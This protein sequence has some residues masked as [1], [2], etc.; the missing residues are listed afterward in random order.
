MNRITF[1][2]EDGMLGP[3]VADLQDALQQCFAQSAIPIPDP[4]TFT[5]LET[6]LQSE[7]TAQTYGPGTHNVVVAFQQGHKLLD[8][9]G[10]ASGAVDEPTASALNALLTQWGLLPPPSPDTQGTV[11]GQLVDGDGAPI[12]GMPVSLF[13]TYI[14]SETRLGDATTGKD[15]RYSIA[16][17]RPSPLNLVTRAYDAS[18]KVIAESTTVFAAAAQVEIN[19]TTA[20]NKVVGSPSIFTTLNSA[21]AGQLR[22]IP[23]S[24]LKE[25]KDTHE[26]HFLAS[27]INVPFEQVAYLFLA[28]LLATEHKLRD[29]TLFGLFTQGTPPTLMSALN[30]LPD[31]GID[32][33]FAAQVL[34][35]VLTHTRATLERTLTAGIAANILPE[36]YSQAEEAELSVLDGLRIASVENAP[37]IRGKTALN[38]LLAAGSVAQNVQT[39]FVQAYAANSGKL[40]PTWK[41][42][43]AD[44]SLPAAD[45]ATLNTVLSAGELLTGNLPLVKDTLQ[46]MSQKTLASLSDLALLDQSDWEARISQVDPGATSIPQVLPGDTAAV[47][48][49][50]FAKSLAARFAGRF[51]TT[52]FVGGLSKAKTT[53]FAHKDELISFLSANPKFNLRSTHI[54]HFLASNKLAIS[55]PALDELKAAQRLHRVSPHYATVDALLSAGYKSAQSVYF[56]GRTPFLAHMTTAMGSETLA[57]TAYARAQMTYATTLMALGQYNSSFSGLSPAAPPLHNLLQARSRTCLT[58]RPCLARSIISIVM[59]ASRFTVQ[60][61]T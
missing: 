59:I 11:L 29:E 26:L 19:F 46:R 13:A 44:K 50:R 36:S 20:A 16:Y 9:N 55:A 30:A 53:A 54:D 6:A 33:A 14:R 25:D 23:L 41:T 27:A 1:P 60:Q 24:A 40:G 52:A 17:D 18:G 21:I 42:L 28:H 8:V 51:Q 48:I 22:D 49:A 39:A 2:L 7:R 3:T 37:Y 58:C 15:G 38:D 61:L 35:A 12:A 34:N 10:V 56:K 47:R 5:Q 45:L 31:A 4:N 32:D 57:S 43:R